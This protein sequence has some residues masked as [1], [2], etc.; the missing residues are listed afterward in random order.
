[1]SI[2][3]QGHFLTFDHGHLHMKIKRSLK[4]IIFCSNG[5]SLIYFTAGSNFATPPFIWVNVTMMDSWEIIASCDLE[6]GLD[7]K[8]ND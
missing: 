4:P 5:L 1:M 7:S 8:L 3:G 2:L 6:F